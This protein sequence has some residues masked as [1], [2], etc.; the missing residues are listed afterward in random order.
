MTG[1]VRA[2]N[3]RLIAGVAG[4]IAQRL[5]VDSM[6]V[7]IAFVVLA[8]AGGFGVLLYGL[9]WAATPVES[10]DRRAPVRAA[11]TQQAVALGMV[12]VGLLLLL[13]GLGLWLGD[14]VVLPIMLAATGSAIVWSRSDEHDRA[15][16]SAAAPRMS[17]GAIRAAAGDPVSPT[18]IVVGTVLVAIAIGGFL[19]A[20]DAIRALWDL[21]LV[22]LAALV[23]A[24]LLFGPWLFRLAQQLGTERRERIRQ[25]ERAELAAHLHDS[26][27]QTLALMQ[28]TDDPQRMASLARRQERELRNW[29]YGSSS[30]SAPKT[31][32]DALQQVAD[33]IEAAHAINVE[34]V[35]VGDVVID[36]RIQALVGALREACVN[37]AKHAHVT[38]IDVFAEVDPAHVTAFVRDRGIGFDPD[39]IPAGR[40]GIHESI[41]ARMQRHGGHATIVSAPDSGTEVEL[42]IPRE[43]PR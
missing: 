1:T 34:I 18:R 31:L 20:N 36:S 24:V 35:A 13:R 8:F 27:L 10:E 30:P 12:V 6:L 28:R 7:R 11:T 19:A 2:R 43:E 25:E 16:W 3:D 40:Q 15:R 4:G 5:G 22:L 29:L 23:G 9:L 42:S 21:G 37:A 14:Q 26:V 33:D 39:H 38:T 17:P 41:R 32:A